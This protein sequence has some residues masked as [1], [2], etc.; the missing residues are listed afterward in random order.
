MEE[1]K[2]I[3]LYA[4]LGIAC[5]S[6]RRLAPR[7]YDALYEN[8]LVYTNSALNKVALTKKG[9]CY[10]NAMRSMPMPRLEWT[11]E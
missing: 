10:V 8:E 6:R 4:L 9:E 1:L 3:E 2:M 11:C 7:V 5:N